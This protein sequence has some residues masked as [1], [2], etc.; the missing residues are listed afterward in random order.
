M[1]SR[2]VSESFPNRKGDFR[3]Y[4]SEERLHFRRLVCRRSAERARQFSHSHGQRPCLCKVD[5]GGNRLIHFAED[6]RRQQHLTLDNASACFRRSIYRARHS[7]S[8][9]QKEKRR[10]IRALIE[11]SAAAIFF[12]GRTLFISTERNGQCIKP[13]LIVKSGAVFC[14]RNRGKATCV[15]LGC[16]RVNVYA[17]K[18]LCL[19]RR[20]SYGIP[21]ETAW[22]NF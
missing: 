11:D 19:I 6:R 21:M 4:F 5:S 18:G 3:F 1:R 8:Y 20:F 14:C 10:I 17:R 15:F 22:R 13:C 7:S 2:K 12:R 9:S 16:R